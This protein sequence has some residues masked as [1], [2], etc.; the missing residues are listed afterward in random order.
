MNCYENFNYLVNNSGYWGTRNSNED[1]HRHAYSIVDSV[2]VEL[3]AC[4]IAN[5]ILIS[6]LG[7]NT[8]R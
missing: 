8:L 3:T 4:G 7:I 2:E 1:S 5:G 6:L